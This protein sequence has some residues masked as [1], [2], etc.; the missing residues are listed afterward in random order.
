[1]GTDSLYTLLLRELRAYL[2]RCEMP[3]FV[4]QTREQLL[5]FLYGRSKCG[6]A[7]Q[8]SKSR[9]IWHSLPANL[10]PRKT[11]ASAKVSPWR[12]DNRVQHHPRAPRALSYLAAR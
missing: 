5:H 4:I 8:N 9:Y 10:E 2:R 3:V 7:R 11:R 1:M 12:L 6:Q